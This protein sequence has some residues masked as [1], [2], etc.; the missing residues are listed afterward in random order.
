MLLFKRLL[1]IG[2]AIIIA[3]PTVFSQTY[4]FDNYSVK[5]GLA[6]SNVYSIV[7]DRS[8]YLWLGTASGITQFNGVKFTNYTTEDGLAENGVRAKV[9]FRPTE[10]IA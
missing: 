5:D 7:Q 9:T 4:F 8:G 6:Q 1:F 2:I 10:S 3:I